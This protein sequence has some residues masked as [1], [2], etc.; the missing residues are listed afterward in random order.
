MGL[1][2]DVNAA[3]MLLDLPERATMADIKSQYRAKI[4]KWHPDRCQAGKDAGN[5]MT[6][7]IIAA[8]RLLGDYCKNYE[9]SFSKEEVIRYL[10]AEDWWLERFGRGS[11]WGNGQQT[12]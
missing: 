4:Q 3:R 2:E 5:Q 1:F 10:P 8:Y 11:L 7:R 9:F 6:A 12:E